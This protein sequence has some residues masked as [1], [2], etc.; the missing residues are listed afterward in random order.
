MQYV[1]NE[2]HSIYAVGHVSWFQVSTFLGRG[3]IEFKNLNNSRTDRKIVF[4]GI[5][6][7]EPYPVP[8]TNRH[9]HQ[10]ALH[11]THCW[12]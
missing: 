11:L 1:R 12:T 6:V 3:F 7:S 8:R 9:I 2:V 5:Y 4:I 10:Q